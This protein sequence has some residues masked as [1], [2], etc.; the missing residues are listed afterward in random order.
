MQ[1]KKAVKGRGK[2]RL[3]LIGPSGSGKTY[4]ALSIAQGLTTDQSKI[5]FIDTE[6][7]SASKYA[8]LFGFDVLELESFAP[9]DYVKAIAAAVKA[10]YEVVVIDSLSHA[11]VGKNGALEMVDK[12]N[13]RS[14]AGNSFAAWREVTPEHNSMVNAIVSSPIHIIATMRSKTEYV[15]EKD[16]RTGKLSPR[17][18][19]LAPVQRDG[20]EYEFDIVADIDHDHKLIV[21]KSRMPLIADA[22]ITKA[23][24]PLGQLI[25]G[26]IDGVSDAIIAPVAEYKVVEPI[27]SE[28]SNPV[29][30]E[31]LAMLKN[32]GKLAKVGVEFWSS[33]KEEYDI[34]SSTELTSRQADK[35]ISDLSDIIKNSESAGV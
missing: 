15:M 22:V 18:I 2:L 16:E 8:D 6:H 28:A 11:W 3:A 9:A 30:G 20:L 5:A 27:V 13:A 21:S 7:G 17:K 35:V 14:K 1:F 29:S 25:K 23:G 12:A 19:G 32:L 31:Q 34:V 10:G 26:W 33:I 4:T 24:A